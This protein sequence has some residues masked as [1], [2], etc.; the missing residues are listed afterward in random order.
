MESFVIVLREG[1]EAALVVA[2]IVAYLRR[3]GREHL[4][5]RVYLGLAIAVL[6]SV[7]AGFALPR[8]FA[9]AI[10]EEAY[11]GVLMLVAAGLILT[12]VIWMARAGKTL[13]EEIEKRVET[14]STSG[15]AAWGVLIFSFLMVFREGAEVV[16]LMTVLSPGTEA[17]TQILGAILGLGLA[18]L[19]GIGFVKGSRRVNLRHFFRV[20][21]GVLVL[22]VII[23]VI[24][25]LHEFG[26]AGILRVG[27]R[28]MALIGPIVNNS[29]LVFAV[30]LIAVAALVFLGGRA[31]PAPEASNGPIPKGAAAERKQAW[32]ARTERRWRIA[33]AVMAVLFVIVLT[34]FHLYTQAPPMDPALPVPDEGGA[35]RIPV[36][37]LA[38]GKL[39]FFTHVEGEDA[40][41]FFAVRIGTD[42]YEVCLDA[43][44]LCGP[45]GYYERGP[46]VICR[47]CTAPIN[48][49]S[50]GIGGGCN[51]IPIPSEVVG[52]EIVIPNEAL[53]SP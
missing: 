15:W 23:L 50:I 17:I 38:D 42:R 19:F 46:E 45:K 28:E 47:N 36:E 39:H 44:V 6:A 14:L 43:C 18:V 12:L 16:L 40:V 11:E 32:L 25:G 3:S 5:G 48:R 1:V 2:I 37:G 27:P 41:R 51:P 22:L 20:T 31:K 29:A 7:A 21:S 49:S 30:M 13:G 35:I 9:S 52:G 33:L 34:G 26:E 4:L 53:H 24:G 10:N 8:L